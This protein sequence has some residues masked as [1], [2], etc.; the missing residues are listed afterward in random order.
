ML[1]NR[2]RRPLTYHCRTTTFSRCASLAKIYDHHVRVSRYRRNLPSFITIKS[3]RPDSSH[4]AFAQT[5]H[6]HPHHCH[7]DT[8]HTGTKQRTRTTPPR[9]DQPCSEKVPTK[10]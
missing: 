1:T 4:P 8:R 3:L 2:V 10:K 9:A 5:Q 7:Y 6:P